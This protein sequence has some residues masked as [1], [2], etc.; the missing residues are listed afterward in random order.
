MLLGGS[1]KLDDAKSLGTASG[2]L[3]DGLDAVFCEFCDG[4]ATFGMESGSTRAV[5][6]E[7]AT[8]RAGVGEIGGAGIAADTAS[9][10]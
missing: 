9:K 2:A 6:D 10:F 8:G 3:L 4:S 1:G 7:S 5:A